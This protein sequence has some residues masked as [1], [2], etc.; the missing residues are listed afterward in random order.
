[1]RLTNRQ[2]EIVLAILAG[3]TTY[4]A[5]AAHLRI[6]WRTAQTHLYTINQ[7][8]GAANM[9]ELVLM[10][11]GYQHSVVDFSVIRSRARHYYL[12]DHGI[13]RVI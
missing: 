5:I 11:T 12:L 4:R 3:H 13:R 6:S 9:V 2:E 1:M 10:A 8:T 7:R